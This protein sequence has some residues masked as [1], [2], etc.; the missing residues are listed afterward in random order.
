MKKGKSIMKSLYIA[1]AIMFIIMTFGFVDIR[2]KFSD[3][4]VFAYKGWNHFFLD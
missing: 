3:G 1:F 4:D 2:L